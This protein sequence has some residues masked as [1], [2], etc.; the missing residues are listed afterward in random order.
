V[1]R[2]LGVVMAWS[3]RGHGV[4]TAW[5]WRVRRLSTGDKRC[6]YGH[7]LS[8][9]VITVIADLVVF[10]PRGGRAAGAPG[11]G[12]PSAVSPPRRC[13]GRPPGARL[14]P[15]LQTPPLPGGGGAP[16]RDQHIIHSDKYMTNI[17]FIELKG[18]LLY[19]QASV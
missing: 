6:G 14:R 2:W 12:Q 7:K 1:F 11:D 16:V 8:S 18:A 3:R 4:V 5:S 15:A 10:L 19:H 13:T 17:A 9:T